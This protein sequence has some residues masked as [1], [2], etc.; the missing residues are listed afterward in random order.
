MHI[1]AK[2]ANALAIAAGVKSENKFVAAACRHAMRKVESAAKHDRDTQGAYAF[3]S[4]VWDMECANVEGWC[5][6]MDY[7]PIWVAD[8]VRRG[9]TFAEDGQRIPCEF[10]AVWES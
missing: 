2:L 3:L 9:D 10:I 5:T 6:Q 8:C 1:N 7:S 4:A